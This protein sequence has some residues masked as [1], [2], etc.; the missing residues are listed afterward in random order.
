MTIR[1]KNKRFLLPGYKWHER[2]CPIDIKSFE[3]TLWDFTNKLRGIKYEQTK[4]MVEG[5]YERHLVI[6]VSWYCADKYAKWAEK[7]LPTEQEWEKT[8]RGEDGRIYPWGNQFDKKSCNSS[9]SGI[10]GTS[11]VDR[12]PQ[13]K[14]PYACY[15]MA[16]NVW[17]WTKSS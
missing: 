15:D 9:E 6:Y 14:S 13:G 17:E 3:E 2:V 7:R 4:F 10:K 16:G 11:K 1:F 8:A 12:L 5:G